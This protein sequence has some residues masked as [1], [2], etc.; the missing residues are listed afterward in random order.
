MAAVSTQVNTL[1]KVCYH[2]GDKVDAPIV[3]AGHVFCCE[4]CKQVYML[5]HQNGMD[6][7]YALASAPGVKASNI[8]QQ[9]RFD[10]LDDQAVAYK[11]LN[12]QEEHLAKITLAIPA[13]HCSS[14]IWLLERLYT[15]QPG[16]LR[17]QVDFLKRQVNI[18]FD[19]SVLTLKALI[20]LLAK[21]GYEPTL[22]LNNIQQPVKPSISRRLTYQLGVAGFC[23]GNIMLISFPEYFGLDSLAQKAFSSFF[24]YLNFALALPVL[25]FSGQD[26]FI[27]AFNGLK[28]KFI[29]IDFPLALGLLVL[30]LRSTYEVF[31]GA[32]IGFFD[33]LAGLVF[34]LLIGKWFQ[35]RTYDA[36]AFD[37]DYTAYFPVA[38]TLVT[39][40][41]ETTLPVT[42]LEVGQII[43]IRNG[44]L[45][46]ADAV[47]LSGNALIDFSF[48][49]GESVPI[50]K[51]KGELIYAGGRQEGGAITL[52]V[53]KKVSQS[54]LTQL[55]NNE[56]FTKP[57]A[58]YVDSFQQKVSKY[59][60]I[61]L[62]TI[63]ILAGV[64]WLQY[65]FET[66]LNAFTAVLI[67][68]CPCALALSSPF[69]LGTAM[70][71][72]G[73]NKWYVKHPGVVEAL[74]RANTLVFD[75]TGTLTVAGAG[76][77]HYHG[78]PLAPTA[79]NVFYAMAA[80][81]THPLA[82]A[83]KA[84]LSPTDAV[85]LQTYQ[86]YSGKGIAASYLNHKYQLGNASFL[87]LDPALNPFNTTRVYL[88]IN[89]GLIGFFEWDQAYRAGMQHTLES[90]QYHYPVH[91]LS[92]DNE[93]EKPFL[94]TIFNDQKR[95]HFNCSP[96]QK[97]AFIQNLD[98]NAKPIMFG[99]GLNDAGALKA[100]YVGVSFTENTA[101]F[102]PASDVIAEASIFN[103]IPNIL[104]FSKNT[105]FVIYCS[106][107]ISLA[108]NLVGLFFAVQGQ[109]SP[110]IAAILMPLSSVTVIAFTTLLTSYFAKKNKLI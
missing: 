86:E 73:K 11:L 51:H 50:A 44:E 98:P 30:M 25:F 76:T 97:M 13:I 21:I 110:L 66:A 40:A 95:L 96:A 32:G 34:F 89:G 107:V 103:K 19:P 55:W 58:S 94:A 45:I 93:G 54:Y 84:A 37:R 77:I 16:V 27:N 82:Q 61:V 59:F 101:L 23:F 26:Y 72:L 42:A 52:K 17:A 36:L 105:L 6:E 1:Q 3:A 70:R 83:L 39:E 60:T 74:A 31:S 8:Q 5:L 88:S 35:Q 15:F 69:A 28:R 78:T 24:G 47:L 65:A 49:T 71:I 102:S 108:Y 14:C 99:D 91:L 29:G 7:Y 68:A 81:S 106:F 33:T 79:I 46:P 90:L 20:T 100:A 64:Y 53:A 9:H 109:L 57:S 22:N 18:D 75:K 43:K 38:V 80:Q 85:V 12:Y 87:Q 48:V 104:R 2:C 62:L 41:G 10:W 56:A 92:G 4:G 67:I 63:A